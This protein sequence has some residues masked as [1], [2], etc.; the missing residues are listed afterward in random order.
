MNTL[1]AES[2]LGEVAHSQMIQALRQ[3]LVLSV[4]RLDYD[5]MHRVW[6]PSYEKVVTLHSQVQSE[7][8]FPLE[9]LILGRIFNLCTLSRNYNQIVEP[10]IDNLPENSIYLES[11][12]VP[13]VGV[14]VG[15]SGSCTAADLLKDYAEN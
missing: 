5:V 7:C 15:N 6:V 4:N 2:F 9:F 12:I 13:Q 1:T 14:Y 10:L 8:P 3:V 11:V